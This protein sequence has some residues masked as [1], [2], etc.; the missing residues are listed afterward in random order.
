MNTEIL[1]RILENIKSGS[2]EIDAAL[3]QLQYYPFEDIGFAK[4]DR[5]RQLPQEFPEVI[6]CSGKTTDQ[7]SEME[8][9]RVKG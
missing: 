9:K 5:H 3:E 8:D 6:F 4:I 2:I 1:K 7:I